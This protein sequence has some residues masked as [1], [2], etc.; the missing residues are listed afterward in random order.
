VFGELNER[1]GLL[2]QSLAEIEVDD[3]K[4]SLGDRLNKFSRSV[5]Q[6]QARMNALED[7]LVTLGQYKDDLNKCQT[8]LAP[9]QSPESGVGALI[10]KIN[11][12]R[13][14]CIVAVDQLESS[15]DQALS[16]RVESLSKSKSEIERRI[17]RLSDCYITIE[18]ICTDFSELK[19]RQEHIER[20]F[21]E[22]E[23]DSNGKNIS[24][25]Q[26]ELRN[27]IIRAHE[28][29]IV[30]QNVSTQLNRYK[31]EFNKSQAELAPLQSSEQGI[32]ARIR[33]LHALRDKLIMNLDE[34][35]SDGDS[36][37]GVRVEEIAKSKLEVERRIAEA[38]DCFAKLDLIRKDIGGLFKKL[39]GSID[40]LG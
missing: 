10:G 32:E 12:L 24:E 38:L 40:R 39:S 34:I 19:E 21:S 15:G 33:D 27:F 36:K 5:T 1:Q 30:L 4:Y 3:N 28:R 25:R 13:D 7:S 2:E 22:V 37:L 20:S 17:G 6:I 35:E 11:A 8:D 14:Q 18:A 9:L 29:F 16:T 31:D 23:T 26:D